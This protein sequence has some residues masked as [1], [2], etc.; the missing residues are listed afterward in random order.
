MRKVPE[1]EGLSIVKSCA[2]KTSKTDKAKKNTDGGGS[3]GGV[4]E[5]GEGERG[6]SNNSDFP[7]S[8]SHGFSGNSAVDASCSDAS[9]SVAN[10]LLKDDETLEKSSR[11]DSNHGR[12]GGKS[13]S[14]GR[15]GRKKGKTALPK[16]RNT[17]VLVKSGGVIPDAVW[18]CG[19]DYCLEVAKGARYVVDEL[20][21]VQHVVWTAETELG[22]DRL[23]TPKKN[24]A[25]TVTSRR[26]AQ[27]TSGEA[28]M[29]SEGSRSSCGGFRE[30]SVQRVVKEEE[31][32]KEREK[33]INRKTGWELDE[34]TTGNALKAASGSSTSNALDLSNDGAD[35]D[36]LS[37]QMPVNGALE[38][39]HAARKAEVREAEARE[40]CAVVLGRSLPSLPTKLKST[41]LP[42]AVSD[43]AKPGGDGTGGTS[44][45]I[46]GGSMGPNNTAAGRR[47]PGESGEMVARRKIDEESSCEEN[48]ECTMN[49]KQ[50]NSE[51][52]KNLLS[53][54]GEGVQDEGNVNSE[55][56]A[57]PKKTASV[58]ENS[59]RVSAVCK[60]KSCS[61]DSFCAPDGVC[62]RCRVTG[63]I[64]TVKSKSDY[65][66]KLGACRSLGCTHSADGYKGSLCRSCR[67][68][69][70]TTKRR[71]TK[72]RGDV[73]S[74]PGSDD[75]D[76]FR[77]SDGETPVHGEIGGRS[78]FIGF[79]HA[80]VII[81]LVLSEDEG[82][83]PDRLSSGGEGNGGNRSPSQSSSSGYFN[84]GACRASPE[85]KDADN[86]SI[87]EDVL[88]NPGGKKGKMQIKKEVEKR[89]RRVKSNDTC[90]S[91]TSAKKSSDDTVTD[92]EQA[93]RAKKN[94]TVKLQRERNTQSAG[95]SSNS[96]DLKD[97]E[98]SS[99]SSGSEGEE[100]EDEE[101]NEPDENSDEEDVLFLDTKPGRRRIERPLDKQQEQEVWFL[102]LRFSSS[103][104]KAI[105]RL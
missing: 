34:S 7:V 84:G 77:D 88:A 80:K 54:P 16:V 96:G 58:W 23:A 55:G 91:D 98:D 64:E 53:F 9:I 51:A 36:N 18:I 89:S 21:T 71:L 1:K 70:N 42:S 4:I 101:Q 24:K 105:V 12:G 83:N 19:Q 31:E 52:G 99:S 56:S 20:Y 22:P 39:Q 49:N 43:R 87:L 65:G 32:E 104:L 26:E 38:A 27:E 63:D 74:G 3:G 103:L 61:C 48:S 92:G 93:G 45:S 82:K 60:T 14:G 75:T 6:C 40:A 100:E 66:P 62:R 59:S 95:D 10:P 44:A 94:K 35:V 78:D 47:S 13:V 85:S 72:F 79:E 11:D 50:P 2:K 73:R 102:G 81:D 86:G 25:T 69:N 46:A 37:G 5:D 8:Q 57:D 28:E 33:F 76:E 29:K 97:T 15:E 30:P 41:F 67:E 17:S 90:D 68:K